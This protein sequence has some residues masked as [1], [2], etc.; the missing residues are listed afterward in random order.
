MLFRSCIA[1]LPHAKDERS[2]A[3][4]VVVE[5]S[6]HL[7]LASAA[8]F[9][10]DAPDGPLR[11]VLAHGWGEEHAGTLAADALLVR[12]LQGEHRPLRL[13]DAQWLP[14]GVPEGA[15]LPV[16]AIPLLHRHL[17][18]AVALYGAHA[19]STLPDPDEVAL[20]HKLAQAAAAAHKRLRE[21]RVRDDFPKAS[22]H[23]AQDPS[24]KSSLTLLSPT[25]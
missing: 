22:P 16:L 5:A 6:R 20:L 25:A 3:E 1:A 21:S 13:H 14:A 23:L 9:F 7:D 15:A 17:L 24:G 8:L 19:N 4:A 18:T 10:R 2:I 11:R 12:Y